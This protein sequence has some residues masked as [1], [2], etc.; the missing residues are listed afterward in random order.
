M[1]RT[2]HT[3]ETGDFFFDTLKIR[4]AGEKNEILLRAAEKRI[5]FRH[6]DDGA[7]SIIIGFY[8]VL[9]HTR[10]ASQSPPTSLHLVTGPLN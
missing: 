7:V 10:K 4:C 8:I 5:N 2:S 3:V 1:K 9:L 6:Y